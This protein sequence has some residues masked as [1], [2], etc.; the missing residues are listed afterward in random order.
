MKDHNQTPKRKLFNPDT[1]KLSDIA[2][3]PAEDARNSPMFIR[4]SKDRI[5]ESATRLCETMVGNT[6]MA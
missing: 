6:L 5:K 3:Q 2:H 4:R 1:S